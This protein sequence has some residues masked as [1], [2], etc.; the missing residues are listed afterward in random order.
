MR[1]LRTLAAAIMVSLF[2]AAPASADKA[3]LVLDASGSMWG[4]IE[5]KSKIEIAREVVGGLLSGWP[6]GT[7]LG[8]MAYGHRE[9]SNCGDIQTLVA[10]APNSGPAIKAAIAD[11]DPKG[12][13]PLTDAVRQ[14][15]KELRSEEGKATVILVS[16]GL[17]T[18]E[19]DP[20][21]VA[22]EL[23]QK[24]IDFTVHVVGFGT[25]GEENR[26]LKC[27]ADNTGGRFLGASN[28]SELKTA[29]AKTVELVA[30]PAPPAASKT[31][32]KKTTVVKVQIGWISLKNSDGYL[33]VLTPAGKEIAQICAGCGRTQ[34]PPGSYKL[35]APGFELDTEVKAGEEKIIDGAPYV[36]WLRLANSD[37]YMKIVGKNGEVVAQICAGCGRQQ[38]PPGTYHLTA[39]GFELDA[40]IAA[41]QEKVIDGAP[42]VGW[43]SLKNAEG[44]AKILRKNGEE[45]AQICAGCGRHQLTPG[46]YDLKSTS[47]E[48]EV[49]I[50]AGEENVVEGAN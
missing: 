47:F 39:V 27:I 25:S 44:Y 16:D 49:E 15:A 50:K 6:T 46:L 9:K 31:V 43:I 23:K 29:M 36:G 12:K 32:E 5:G 30:K 40:E 10:P 26:Q 4:Q 17:E 24:G 41:G 7:E 28:A 1:I 3:M 42:Y 48:V 14:A 38:L 21:A 13:T 33:K 37:G 35:K 45:V 22:A 11:I 19:A 34:V 8:L 2:L 18:C 20:C